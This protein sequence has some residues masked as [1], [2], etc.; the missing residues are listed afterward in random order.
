MQDLHLVHVEGS[1]LEVHQSTY[2]TTTILISVVG[3][4]YLKRFNGWVKALKSGSGLEVINSYS[5]T[6]VGDS[7]YRE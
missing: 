7:L 5:I 1:G 3:Q 6:K 4:F 2:Q